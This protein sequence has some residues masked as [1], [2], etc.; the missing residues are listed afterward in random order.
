VIY[1]SATAYIAIVIVALA[2]GFLAL[3]ILVVASLLA[4]TVSSTETAV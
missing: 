4:A 1:S 3:L 2:E